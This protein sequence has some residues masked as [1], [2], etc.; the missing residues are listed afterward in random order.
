[1][2]YQTKAQN[3]INEITAHLIRNDTAITPTIKLKLDLLESTLIDYFNANQLIKEMGY[4][5]EFNKGT[6]KGLNPVVKLKQDSLK[7]ALKILRDFL[8]KNEEDENV[9]EFINRLITE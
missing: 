6:S 2:R 1:M 9:D 4:L 8:P 3:I 5:M 7:N